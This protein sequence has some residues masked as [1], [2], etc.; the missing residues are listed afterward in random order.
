M[1]HIDY[2][3][4]AVIGLI[5]FGIGSS[6]TINNFFY[7][8][9]KPRSIFVGL[10]L[11]IILLP[12]ITLLFTS[13]SNLEPEIKAGIFIVSIC[14]GGTISNFICY[15]IK[16]DTA[17]SVTLTVINSFIVLFTIPLLLKFGLNFYDIS[18]PN[19]I[20]NLNHSIINL[21][22]IIIIPLFTGTL[23]NHIAPAITNKLKNPL[24]IFNLILLCLVFGIKI[25]ANKS[26]GG[27]GI[28]Y[29]NLTELLPICLTIHFFSMI[30]SYFIAKLCVSNEFK[31]I[32]IGIE[33]GLQNTTLAL[34]IASVILNNDT[35]SKPAL[36]FAMFTF[37]T[38]LIFAFI[39]KK[40]TKYDFSNN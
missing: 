34:F 17:L 1:E 11:Q 26:S 31:A 10:A 27:S 24:K 19:L 5:M 6:L 38:S 4:S 15:I 2:L 35:I 3:L 18:N 7:N 14:P 13:F 21:F 9:K 32:T 20:I 23:L 16:L 25:F 8:I 12:L 30:S 22:V 33:V 39:T 37:F 29:E 40:I 36:V 28:S